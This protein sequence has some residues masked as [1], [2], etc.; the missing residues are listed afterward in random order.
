MNISGSQTFQKLHYSSKLCFIKRPIPP[1]A[2]VKSLSQEV[3]DEFVREE[4]DNDET[5]LIYSLDCMMSSSTFAVACQALGKIDLDVAE[6]YLKAMKDLDSKVKRGNLILVGKDK[7]FQKM[8]LENNGDVLTTLDKYLKKVARKEA[9]MEA[10]LFTAMTVAMEQPSVQEWIGEKV[11][12]LK[13]YGKT[14]VRSLVEKEGYNWD[15]TK[16]VFGTN[17]NGTENELLRQAWIKG[18]RPYPKGTKE[19][20][21][22]HLMDSMDWL[23]KN[24]KY[25]TQ[26]LKNQIKKAMKDQVQNSQLGGEPETEI[27]TSEKDENGNYKTKKVVEFSDESMDSVT[28]ADW[29]Y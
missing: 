7:K 27:M 26:T 6:K 29:D 11:N 8:L 25:Q 18:W 28:D 4:C 16:K 14:N 3:F 15:Y 1:G 24:P 22:Q 2:S 9:V 10:S 21:E 20:T 17:S 19:P 23:E 12:Y 13:H 5:K